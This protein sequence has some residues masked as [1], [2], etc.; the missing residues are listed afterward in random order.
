MKDRPDF[1][2]DAKDVVLLGITDQVDVQLPTRAVDED[3]PFV[4]TDTHA[5]GVTRRQL[6]WLIPA[7]LL[8][9]FAIVGYAGWGLWDGRG[10]GVPADMAVNVS[11][12]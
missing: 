2:G 1:A 10:P 8:A 11:A 6:R 3:D 4:R 9:V 7:S 5:G 12:R